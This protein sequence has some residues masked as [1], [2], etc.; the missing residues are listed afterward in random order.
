MKVNRSGAQLIVNDFEV[1]LSRDFDINLNNKLRNPEVILSKQAEYSFTFDLPKTPHNNEVFQFANVISVS[2]K[3]SRIYDC[4]LNVDGLQLF[5]GKLTISEIDKSSYRC[6]LVVVKVV[7]LEEIFGDTKLSELDWYVP[8]NGIST[9]NQVN[10]DRDSKYWFPYACYGA[11]A[12]KPLTQYNTYNEY[13]SIYS[14]DYTN[15]FYCSTFY[16]SLNMLEVMR[17]CFEHKGYKLEGT[18]LKDSLLDKVYLSTSLGSEQVPIYNLGNSRFGRVQLGGKF[19]NFYLESDGNNYT[20]PTRL[21]EIVSLDYPY[22]EW[23]K[24]KFN[25]EEVCVYNLLDSGKSTSASTVAETEIKYDTFIYA[26]G[27]GYITIPSDGLYR[28]H[29][30]ANLENVISKQEF[31]KSDGSKVEVMPIGADVMGV[32]EYCYFD[33]DEDRENTPIGEEEEKEPLVIVRWGEWDNDQRKE[34]SAGS[35]NKGRTLF[36]QY[37]PMEIQLVKNYDGNKIEL[38]KGCVSYTHN[39]VNPNFSQSK[40]IVSAYPH[41]QSLPN[42]PLNTE[43]INGDANLF[44]DSWF[45]PGYIPDFHLDTKPWYGVAESETVLFDPV[46]NPNFICGLSSIGRCAS[47]IKN[48]YSWY[49]GDTYQNDSIVDNKGYNK[50]EKDGDSYIKSSSD[51][52]KGTL[53]GSQ[54]KVNFNDIPFHQAGQVLNGQ[55][56]CMVYLNK[57]DRLSLVALTRCYDDMATGFLGMSPD[58]P[59]VNPDGTMVT[60]RD[61]TKTGT[62]PIKGE[63]NLVVEAVAEEHSDKFLSSGGNWNTKTKFSEELNLGQFLSNDIKMSDFVNDV[64]KAFNLSFSQNEKIVTMDIQKEDE[65]LGYSINIDDRVNTKDAELKMTKINYPSSV[66]VKYNINTKEA[67]YYNTVPKERLNKDTWEKYGSMG[68]DK[69]ELDNT[70]DVSALENQLGFSYTWYET[71]KFHDYNV[72]EKINPH[73][74][75]KYTAVTETSVTTTDLRIPVQIDRE[76][77]VDRGNIEQ[78][79]QKDGYSLKQ[80]LWFRQFHPM[81]SNVR[82]MYDGFEGEDRVDLYI[83]VRERIE[84]GKSL[85]LSYYNKDNSL[86]R[87]YFN[88]SQGIENNY[89]EIDCHLSPEEYYAL[90]NGAYVVFNSDKYK[91]AEISKYSISHKS[92]C[93]L[94]LFKA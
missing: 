65:I 90:K 21:G 14:I 61:W 68:Y 30:D 56:E 25:F 27:D 78:Y 88:I 83:P 87:R 9:I 58:N 2:N 16:P 33:D 35:Q 6:N 32:G 74:R 93:T 85:E 75:K 10:A 54:T 47:V 79:M 46:V 55:V 24:G 77:F 52:Q 91:V 80:R 57:D 13:T 76:Y 64:Q 29:L 18:V 71:F 44:A 1:D 31:T 7:T 5:R 66:A 17:R 48:G 26:D 70:G 73:S 81:V 36:R 8:F 37:K 59:I 40:A 94:K 51:F 22:D 67:G 19:Q 62:Y 60:I 20:A 53:E 63:F 3:F 4:E 43:S 38:I 92:P 11:F 23:T 12:K 86:L 39:G 42:V 15:K 89:V 82:T 49:K 34:V 41:E 50:Y 72:E 69:I 45:M 28:I 84:D